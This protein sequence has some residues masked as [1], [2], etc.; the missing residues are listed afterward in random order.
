MS[1]AA[2]NVV[3]R[4]IPAHYI[5]LVLVLAGWSPRGEMRE[6]LDFVFLAR[7]Q[8]SVSSNSIFPLLNL[9]D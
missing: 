2:R 3:A 1:R 8:T 7:G 6:C 4:D 5:P 9:L